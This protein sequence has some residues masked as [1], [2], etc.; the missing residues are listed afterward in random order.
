MNVDIFAYKNAEYPAKRARSSQNPVES[1]RGVQVDSHLDL[2]DLA[3]LDW[4]AHVNPRL[5]SEKWDTHHVLTLKLRTLL[6]DWKAT[7][8][9]YFPF[10]LDS[11]VVHP[12]INGERTLSSSCFVAKSLAYIRLGRCR[13]AVFTSEQDSTIQ[14]HRTWKDTNNSRREG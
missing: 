8:I 12:P 11:F 10:K 6:G 1:T 13:S 3:L 4:W 2:L 14:T 5:K 9:I 7:P